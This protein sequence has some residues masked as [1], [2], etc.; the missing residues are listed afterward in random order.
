M[1][2]ALAAVNLPCSNAAP[3]IA[4]RNTNKPNPAGK[5]TSAIN[6]IPSDDLSSTACWSWRLIAAR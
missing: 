4:R 1:L 2:R 6:R 3:T 5:V